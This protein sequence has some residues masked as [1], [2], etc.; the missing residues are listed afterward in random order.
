LPR[1]DP[2]QTS[3]RPAFVIAALVLGFFI[4]R[5]WF[6][7]DDAFILFRYSKNLGTGLGLTYNPGLPPVEAF[8]ETLWTLLMAIPE[9]LG[10]DAPVVAPWITAAGSLFLLWRVVAYCARRGFGAVGLLATG[11]FIATSPTIAIWSTSGLSTSLSALLI[12]LTLEALF[13][14]RSVE[15]PRFVAAG[16]FGVGA[17]L[18]RADA[19]LWIALLFGL[20]LLGVLRAGTERRGELRAWGTGLAILSV[21]GALFLAWRYATFGDWLPNTARAK[22]GVSAISL[23]RGA[24]Y[25][26]HYWAILPA[27]ATAFALGIVRLA[28]RVKSDVA[29][30]DALDVATLLAAATFAYSVFVGG[31]FM[32]MGRFFFPA[33]IFLALVFG[34]AIDQL[35]SSPAGNRRASLGVALGLLLVSS[36]L[37]SFDLHLASKSVRESLWFRWSSKSY[38]S[39]YVFWQGMHDRAEEWS[40]L[41]KALALHTTAEDSLVLGPIGA[42]GYYSKVRIYDQYGLVSRE[43]L[44]ASQPATVRATP[45]HDRLVDPDFFDRFKPTYREAWLTRVGTP[46][47]NSKRKPKMHVYQLPDELAAGRSLVLKRW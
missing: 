37:P 29:A 40:L 46:V 16:V 35:V 10:V 26:L 22:V 42:V 11:I 30:L 34:E 43:V 45:G 7:C 20:A 32:A 19:P 6:V 12:F 2:G 15:T 27:V 4:A 25:V 38:E 8:T 1:R 13:P 24:K 9:A 41:G 5:F 33:V 28:R 21:A 31:D 47:R 17:S 14:A 23:E 44:S 18:M 3:A 36:I 39:E